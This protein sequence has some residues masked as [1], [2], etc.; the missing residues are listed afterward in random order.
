[1]NLIT[2]VSKNY[3][4]I[5][6]YYWYQSEWLPSLD[7][8]SREVIRDTITVMLKSSSCI[9]CSSDR[10]RSINNHICLYILCVH[11][12]N[13]CR[14]VALLS[15]HRAIIYTLRTDIACSP[16]I[17]VIFVSRAIYHESDLF[18]C[19]WWPNAHVIVKGITRWVF[20]IL[21]IISG[22]P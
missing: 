6:N 16:E 11:S 17:V 4:V 7:I 19:E 10:S 2:L 12:T 5:Q 3:N 22:R 13:K 1:M 14:P 8:Q 18:Y 9:K 20:F 15:V 21:F